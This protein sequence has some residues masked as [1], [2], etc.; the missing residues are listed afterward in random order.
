[1]GGERFS[2]VSHDAKRVWMSDYLRWWKGVWARF[3]Q[4]WWS[5]LAGYVFISFIKCCLKSKAVF[6]ITLFFLFLL[7]IFII[8]TVDHLILWSIQFMLYQTASKIHIMGHR[9]WCPWHATGRNSALFGYCIH[10]QIYTNSVLVWVLM[11]ARWVFYDWLNV[12]TMCFYC[13]GGTHNQ[14]QQLTVCLCT[15]IEL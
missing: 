7:Y 3:F 12:T 1:M 11:A 5:L 13:N 15:T 10:L 8:S 9:K 4:I 14:E 2:W 6:H